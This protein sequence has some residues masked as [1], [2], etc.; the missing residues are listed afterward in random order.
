MKRRLLLLAALAPLAAA[1]PVRAEQE[2]PLCYNYGCNAR[3]EVRFSGQDLKRIQ[4]AFEGVTGPVDERKAI[5]AAMALLYASAAAQSPIWRD[6]GGNID[7][8]EVDGRMD[9][10]DHS[11]NTTEWLKLLDERGW[12]KHHRV[13]ERVRRGRWLIFEHWSARIVEADTRAEFAVDTWFL[14]PG[15]P[16][17]IYPL[18]EWLDGAYPPG[19]EPIRWN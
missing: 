18:R 1:L 15:E 17:V 2:A 19:R 8:A 10:I 5:A 7:D 12:L 3:V 16:A 4:A 6:R 13:G 9:C 14:D 11:T